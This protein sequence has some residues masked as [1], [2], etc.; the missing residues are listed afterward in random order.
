MNHAPN[1]TR[2]LLTQ[3]VNNTFL[4]YFRVAFGALMIWCLLKYFRQDLIRSMY[5]EPR[6][7]F[8][9]LGFDW[10]KPWPAAGM[11][12]HVLVTAVSAACIMV[13]FKYRL[14]TTVFFLSFTYIFLLDQ[15]WY[16]NHY[17]LIC[18]LGFL[19]IVL[20][21]DRAFSIDAIR[22]PALRADTVPMWVLWILRFQ[23]GVPYFFGGIAKLNSDWFHGEPIRTWL[24]ESTDFPLIGQYFTS[25][26]CVDLF[27]WGG[28]LLDL[29]VV[30]LLLWRPTRLLTL[31]TVWLFHGMNSQL[32]DIGV[33][34]WLMLAATTLVYVP[35]EWTGRLRL[36]QRRVETDGPADGVH[37]QPAWLTML[38]CTFVAIQLLIPF[39]HF[40]YPGHVAFTREGHYF[41]WRMKLNIRHRDIQLAVHYADGRQ[42][43]V[44]LCEWVTY[45][46][47]GRLLSTGQILQLARFIREHQEKQ[48]EMRA[49]VHGTITAALNGREPAILVSDEVDLSRQRRNLLPATWIHRPTLPPIGQEAV[50]DHHTI[51]ED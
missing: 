4:V 39:R 30:P 38:M 8:T 45:E 1:R 16:L 2:R 3:P 17:Y 24:A 7:H 19:L 20:P 46:Q 42:E 43:P 33:F 40:L 5:L 50:G 14:A 44:D 49:E 23:I 25:E 35:P 32:F 27:V 6:M 28:L 48:G 22:N 13:G 12:A 51:T 34:P 9:Y 10:V 37:R 26:W 31:V 36:W 29:F 21:A 11:Y 18:L 15:S 47:F 41:S